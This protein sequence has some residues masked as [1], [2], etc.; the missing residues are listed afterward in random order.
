MCHRWRAITIATPT[1]WSDIVIPSSHPHRL[2][3]ALDVARLC[4][5]RSG[6][7]PISLTWHH[8]DWNQD[9]II[10][11]VL[12]P[13]LGRLENLTIF[14]G[15]FRSR[16]S[17]LVVLGTISFTVLKSFRCYV[18]RTHHLANAS[19]TPINIHA[20][21]LRH[22]TF[23]NFTIPTGAFSSLI[24]LEITL[25]PGYIWRFDAS[26]IFDLLREIAQT[27]K[28]LRFR[29]PDAILRDHTSS[30]PNIQLPKLVTLDL[31]SAS[32]LLTLISTPNLHTLTLED[33]AEALASP[34]TSFHAPKL[35][36]L[37]LD[38]I[39]L[40]D[41]ETVSDFPWRFQKL[42]SVVLYH[43]QSTK[44]FF[45]HAS[46]T[47]DSIPGFPSLYSIV[48]SDPDTFPSIRSMVEG[49]NAAGP[50]YPTL[51][52]LRFVTWNDALGAGDVEWLTAQGIDFSEGIH[53]GR[54]QP[55][56]AF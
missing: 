51:K 28:T 20:P 29:A 26:K 9:P 1:L 41:L 37:E 18:A 43:C 3:A 5:E 44:S 4:V 53:T 36:H 54:S 46:S 56:K 8:R 11:D 24:T 30:T 42:E 38:G 35:K 32:G 2:R 50:G 21:H 14:T 33:Y 10:H 19:L 52:R 17:L 39:P 27:L 13:V 47:R 49:R 25:S 31:R 6:S 34:F 22:G 16:D 48:F 55:R 23:T 45:H 12:S 40:L 7:C 15:G